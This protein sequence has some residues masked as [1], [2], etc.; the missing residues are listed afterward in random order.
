[1]VNRKKETKPEGTIGEKERSLVLSEIVKN[2]F[3][4]NEIWEIDDCVRM[5]FDLDNSKK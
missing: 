4:S 5:L 3:E 1:M 2:H